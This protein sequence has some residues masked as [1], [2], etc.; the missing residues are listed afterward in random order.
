MIRMHGGLVL[1]AALSASGVRGAELQ[2]E[3]L[4]DP[5]CLRS[6]AIGAV[7]QDPDGHWIAWGGAIAPGLGHAVLIGVRTDTGEARQFDLS[8]YGEG[9]VALVKGVDG[10]VY[11]YAG[12]PAHFLKYDVTRRELRDLGSPVKPA[13]YYGPGAL[14]PDGRFYVGSYPT[15]SLACCDT[16]TGKVANL[17]RL[18]TDARQRYVFPTVAVSDDG[19]VY[20]SVGLHHME[21]WSYD[22]TTGAKRQILPDAITKRQGAPR[23]WTGVDGQ[24]YAQGG[25]AMLCRP[26]GVELGKTAPARPQ[27]PLLAGTKQV[28]EINAEGK[29]RLVDIKTRKTAWLPTTYAGHRV[30]IFSVACQRDGKIY[31]S[32]LLPGHSFSYDVNS[33]QLVDLG[34]IDSG[35]CQVYDTISLPRGLFLASYFGAFVDL[36]DPAAPLAPGNNPRRLGHAPGQERPVQWALGPDG[37]LYTGTMPAKG[38]LGGALLRVNPA[39]LSLKI[40]P[41]PIGN[42]SVMYVAAAPE[43]RELFCTTSI[44]GGSSAVP[45]EKEACVFLWDVQKE[46]LAFQTQPIPGA[47]SYGRAVRARNG[48][49]YGLA[50][51]R[52]YVF[53]PQTRRVTHTAALPVKTLHFPQLHDEPVGPAGLIIGLGD[54]AVFAIDPANHGVRVLARHESLRRAHGFLV[55]DD[56]ALYYGSG[57]TLMRVKLNLN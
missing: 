2:F 17:G 22:V 45:S 25:R 54:D 26:D 18:P 55:T 41:S 15:A 30:A 35:R 40:W 48:L 8:K 46:A 3:T 43:T 38:R 37:M 34:I 24:V 4:G 50:G 47:T 44:Q 23:V 28:G 19:V 13:S 27:P 56:G 6:L 5:V 39:D 9:K 32:S 11:V 12:S 14:G 51:D 49:I 57:A 7:T 31:G 1:L 42:Q 21:L 33:G 10:N 20:S 36:Y 52:Y 16:R 29:L 53:A